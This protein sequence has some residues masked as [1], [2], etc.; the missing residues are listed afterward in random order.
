MS[1]T[2]TTMVLVILRRKERAATLREYPVT[3]TA[4]STF[5]R[6]FS[7]TI[8]GLV[9]ARETVAVEQPATLATSFTVGIP[10]L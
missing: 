10:R 1:G 3:S 9:K 7:E 8:S 2:T 6:V 5:L 4:C